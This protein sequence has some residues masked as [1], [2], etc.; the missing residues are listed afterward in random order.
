MKY[1]VEEMFAFMESGKRVK[2]TCDTGEV[3]SGTCVAYSEATNLE[4]YGVDEPSIEV[5]DT[6]LFQRDIQKIEY[7][8]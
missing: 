7:I 5:Q 2:V 6:I 8:N 1:T 4:E 3:F